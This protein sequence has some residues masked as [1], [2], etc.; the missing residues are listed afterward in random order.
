MRELAEHGNFNLQDV[1]M[2]IYTQV[3]YPSIEFVQAE[4]G[5]PMERTHWI[6]DRWGYTGSACLPMC[7][8]EAVE[9]G[10]VKSGDLVTFV[11]SGVGYNQ[12]GAAFVMP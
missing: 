1:D 2:A 7:F 3:R 4:L 10:K 11:G 9:L 12:A 8:D 5:L 6:M